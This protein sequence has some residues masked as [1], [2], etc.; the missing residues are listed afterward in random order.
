MRHNVT[1]IL[2]GSVT[3]MALLLATMRWFFPSDDLVV[4]RLGAFVLGLA[5]FP[6]SSM[7]VDGLA[8]ILKQVRE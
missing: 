7:A 2:I 8:N 5:A 6:F 4:M 1:K 3:Y